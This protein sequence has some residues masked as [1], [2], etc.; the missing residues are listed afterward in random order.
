M[1]VSEGRIG[2]VFT[3]R[4]EDG[5]RLPESLES[6]AAERG[7]ECAVVLLLGGAG[8]GSRLVVGPEPDRGLGIV[9]MIHILAGSQEIAAMGTLFPDESG[10]PVLH[11]H[12]A[13]GREGKATVGCTRAGV[14][15]W[16]VGE[17]VMMEVLGTG[18]VR[19]KDPATG[20][21]LLQ[22]S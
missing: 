9:P 16:L 1:Q 4:L 19:R 6:L 22:F 2:R 11:M 17:V 10:R 13:V 15:V 8:D 20:L 21:Q 14:K 3:L 5:D 18:G 7:V 12:A